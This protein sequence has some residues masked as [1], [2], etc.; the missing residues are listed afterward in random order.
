M[1][2]LPHVSIIIPVR[3]DK[4]Y[5]GGLVSS[6]LGGTYS[7]E[8]LEILIVDGMST[9]GSKEILRGLSDKNPNVRIFEN[10]DKFTPHALNIGV[11]NSRGEI[12][13]IMGAHSKVPSDFVHRA[14]L[15]INKSGADC[16]GGVRKIISGTGYVSESIALA[17]ASGFG[18]G[19]ADFELGTEHATETDTAFRPFYRKRVFREIGYFNEKLI[20]SQ[21]ME[22]SIRLKS[23][24]GRII[25]DPKLVSYYYQKHGFWDFFKHNFIDGVWAVYPFKFVRIPLKLRHYIPLAFVVFLLSTFIF[26]FFFLIFK[27]LFILALVAYLAAD[28]AFS[29]LISIKNGNKYFLILPFIFINRH[30][31]YGIGSLWGCVKLWI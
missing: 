8:K 17:L 15:S 19:N 20:R 10:K 5:I 13:G 27:V 22:F 9:D 11:K 26:G 29:L 23:A 16:V 28:L 24:G 2:E 12:I 21:D 7:L 25:T 6:I 3:N 18:A 30:F 14:V 31:G 1:E 4:K